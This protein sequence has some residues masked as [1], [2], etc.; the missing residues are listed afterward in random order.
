MKEIQLKD[1][2]AT[3]SAVVDEAVGGNAS[4]ITRHGLPTAVIISYE[5]YQR[6]R[7]VPSFGWLLANAP[8]EDDD[9]PVRKPARTTVSTDV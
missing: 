1:A 7:Q 4:L 8:L 6:L 3:L 2:K 9:L 5:E